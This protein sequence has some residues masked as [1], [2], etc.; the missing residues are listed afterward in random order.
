[1]YRVKWSNNQIVVLGNTN[2]PK[3]KCETKTQT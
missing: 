1:M 2:G 3:F